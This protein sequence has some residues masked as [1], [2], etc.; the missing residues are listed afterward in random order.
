MS[1]K[2]SEVLSDAA[3]MLQAEGWCRGQL[4]VPI[5]ESCGRRCVMGAIYAAD[6]VDVLKMHMGPRYENT[7]ALEAFAKYIGLNA[8]GTHLHF[9]NDD[10]DRAR[11]ADEVI[12]AL[13]NCA[14][15]LAEKGQ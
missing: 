14:A 1:K 8:P 10:S 9:W 11:S 3:D 7:A 15:E 12:A 5:E 13:R 4:Q 6:G 2:I